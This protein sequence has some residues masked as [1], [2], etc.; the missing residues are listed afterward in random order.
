AAIL[1]MPAA[2][3]HPDLGSAMQAIRPVPDEP[4][5]PQDLGGTPQR[6]AQLRSTLYPASP[7]DPDPAGTPGPLTQG[8]PA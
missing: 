8:A 6:Y 1:A 4:V 7:T 2:G 5:T 3:L